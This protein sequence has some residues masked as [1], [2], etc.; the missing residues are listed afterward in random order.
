MYSFVPYAK[1]NG[2]VG[3]YTWFPLWF[4]N[5]QRIVIFLWM[6]IPFMVKIQRCH[7]KFTYLIQ[8]DY[9]KWHQ[10]YRKPRP[11]EMKSFSG[12]DLLCYNCGCPWF[13]SYKQ[14]FSTITWLALRLINDYCLYRHLRRFDFLKNF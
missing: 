13:F 2:K 12:A 3:F 8:S 6:G 14:L 1:M 11:F 10:L 7:L 5:A 4:I 9:I